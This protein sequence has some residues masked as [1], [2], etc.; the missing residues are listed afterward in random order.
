MR[1]VAVEEHFTFPDLLGRIDL[2]TLD[3]NGWPAPGTAT[4]NAISPPALAD[5][6]RDRIADMDAAAVDA[7]PMSMR[8]TFVYGWANSPVG[9]AMPTGSTMRSAPVTC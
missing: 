8:I 2:A 7:S 5:T 9:L 6:G 4:L 1:I 3:R